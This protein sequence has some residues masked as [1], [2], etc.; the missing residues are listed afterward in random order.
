MFKLVYDTT[1]QRDLAHWHQN[2]S[3]ALVSNPISYGDLEQR[4]GMEFLPEVEIR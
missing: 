3:Y 1:T 2:S 4:I